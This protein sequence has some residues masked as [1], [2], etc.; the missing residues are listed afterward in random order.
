MLIHA[1]AW[2]NRV[3]FHIGAENLRS[4]KAIEKL[5]AKLDSLRDDPIHGTGIPYAY[6]V[7]E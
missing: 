3:W 5:G 2:A 1:F 7:M 4:R 6:Y